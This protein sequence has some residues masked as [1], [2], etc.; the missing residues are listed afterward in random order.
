MPA[1]S[2]SMSWLAVAMVPPDISL[3]TMSVVFTPMRWPRS[4][5]VMASCS[6]M[7]FFSSAIS[8]IC[9]F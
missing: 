1:V 7:I 4:E 9:V 6:R 8:V 5:T 3:R 2:A